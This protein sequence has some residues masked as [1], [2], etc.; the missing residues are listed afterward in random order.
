PNPLLAAIPLRQSTRAE[1]DG[2]A[3]PAAE[4]EKLRQAAEMPGGGVV[5]L[6]ERARI[7]QV[8]DL[9]VAGNGA[10]M[11]DPAFMTELKQ[12][13]RFN[14]RAA[15]ASGDGLFSASSGNPVLPGFLGGPAFDRFV[16]AAGESEKYARQID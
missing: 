6:T 3:V 2:R 10:Q 12:W 16:T 9:V 8:R 4:I 11:T 1:Y 7:D 13:L 14:P 15:I 5:L